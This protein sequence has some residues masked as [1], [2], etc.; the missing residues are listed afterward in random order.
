MS[1]SVAKQFEPWWEITS[2]Q[3]VWTKT[4]SKPKKTP[5]RSSECDKGLF[6]ALFCK[7]GQGPSRC[8][9]I[10]GCLFI[11]VTSMKRLL[12]NLCC[13]HHRD[14]SG[15]HQAMLRRCC[16]SSH[17]QCIQPRINTTQCIPPQKPKAVPE[18]ALSYRQWR[19]QMTTAPFEIESWGGKSVTHPNPE[20]SLGNA[21]MMHTIKFDRGEMTFLLSSPCPDVLG[22]QWVQGGLES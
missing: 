21:W 19:S 2:W 15:S 18:W 9:F 1:T 12:P 4:K 14:S 13:L 8:S 16:G 7:V 22:L 10:Q 20:L 3:D 17:T 6:P 11:T 5:S